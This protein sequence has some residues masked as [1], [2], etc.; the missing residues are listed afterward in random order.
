MVERHDAP[1]SRMTDQ[2]SSSP[3]T[4]HD[5]G[6][7]PLGDIIEQ[8]T[9]M[10]GELERF[11]EQNHARL[12]ELREKVRADA[13]AVSAAT[14]EQLQ[15]TQFERDALRQQ[16]ECL[17]E[18]VRRLQVERDLAVDQAAE[19]R[20]RC[21]Q[22]Q[23]QNAQFDRVLQILKDDLEKRDQ[24]TRA[25]R[26][27]YEKLKNEHAALLEVVGGVGQ[28]EAEIQPDREALARGRETTAPSS[29]P[30]LRVVN[31]S[32]KQCG[33]ALQA[34]ER[35]AGLVMK[36]SQCGRVVPVPKMSGA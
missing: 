17:K 29:P 12:T 35:R 25:E 11:A 5:T 30:G 18:E 10:R 33:A 26:S 3:D 19:L 34:T 23:V 22:Q 1:P 15:L 14:G 32:C 6:S 31:F 24:E 8:L 36:C 4:V 16:V 21:E 9:G 20:H 27:R 2:D 28:L 7:F 13:A